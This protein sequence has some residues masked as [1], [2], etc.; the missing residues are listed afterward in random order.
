MLDAR[1]PHPEVL[2]GCRVQ[3]PSRRGCRM[4]EDDGAHTDLDA[5]ASVPG[6]DQSALL[7]VVSALPGWKRRPRP[8]HASGPSA[9]AGPRDGES[10]LVAL[11]DNIL[12][13]H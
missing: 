1:H 9:G 6:E 5:G 8:N 2:T 12:S 11:L 3:Q 10:A 7:F 13:D 4:R